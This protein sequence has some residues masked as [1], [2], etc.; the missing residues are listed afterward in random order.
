M[1]MPMGGKV[2]DSINRSLFIEP[3]EME[4][5]EKMLSVK[6][7]YSK[8]FPKNE[9]VKTYTKEFPYDFEVDIEI[10]N[11]DPPFV[12]GVLYRPVEEGDEIN[13]LEAD[14]HIAYQLSGDYWFSYE[15]KTFRFRVKKNALFNKASLKIQEP[16]WFLPILFFGALA[17]LSLWRLIDSFW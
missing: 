11:S 6:G 4:K 15:G 17:I 2:P 12:R 3:E 8:D 9:I 7:G 14:E 5:W 1:P 10:H 13:M 16:N